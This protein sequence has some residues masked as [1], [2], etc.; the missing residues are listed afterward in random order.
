[1]EGWR[2]GGLE[3]WRVI[4]KGGVKEGVKEGF[5]VG[6]G[7][8]GLRYYN[9]VS[10][11]CRL[12]IVSPLR[13]PFHPSVFLH[14]LRSLLLLLLLLLPAF[15][16]FSPPPLPFPSIPSPTSS[17]IFASWLVFHNDE[18]CEALMIL[19][20]ALRVAICGLWVWGREG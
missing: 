8:G 1:L 18:A 14:Y 9:S 2:V 12:L 4:V 17:L 5:W 13:S 6:V 3:G 15:Q 7:G 10:I 11:S 19:G 16:I 20:I